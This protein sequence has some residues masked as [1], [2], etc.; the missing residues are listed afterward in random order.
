[1]GSILFMQGREGRM[2]V[3]ID[4]LKYKHKYDQARFYWNMTKCSYRE[5]ARH[6]GVSTERAR[7]WELQFYKDKR[8]KNGRV[9]K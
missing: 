7:R 5:L 6:A 3:V 4:F 8:K 9:K 2:G 1:M